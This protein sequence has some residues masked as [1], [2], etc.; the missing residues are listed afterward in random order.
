MFDSTHDS[1][2]QIFKNRR[3]EKKRRKAFEKEV[4][5]IK[6]KSTVYRITPC[7]ISAFKVEF[8][9]VIPPG[10][11]SAWTQLG[12]FPTQQA[13]QDAIHKGIEVWAKNIAADV[14]ECE[15]KFFLSSASYEYPPAGN[16][17]YYHDAYFASALAESRDDFIWTLSPSETSRYYKEIVNAER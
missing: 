12:V 8:K 7:G 1:L 10:S 16:H 3:R 2:W 13:A 5:D 9:I 15:R 17:R 4:A 6:S 14:V 11:G